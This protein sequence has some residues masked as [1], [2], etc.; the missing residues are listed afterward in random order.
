[1][2]FRSKQDNPDEFIQKALKEDVV[3]V[4]GNA[5]GEMGEGYIRL[6]YAQSYENLQTAMERLAKIA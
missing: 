4:N 5:F 3:L 2:L 6:S 1:M